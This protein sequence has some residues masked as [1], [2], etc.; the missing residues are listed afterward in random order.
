MRSALFAGSALAM[1]LSPGLASAQDTGAHESVALEEIVVTAQRREENLQKAALP[2][3]AVSQDTLIDAG[4]TS[5]SDLTKVVP[6]LQVKP[7]AGPYPLFYL[8]GVGNFNGNGLS[9]S[10][11]AFNV[12]NVYIGRP[13]SSGGFFYDLERMEVLKG[14]QGTL[15]GRNATGGAI[16]VITKKPELGAFGGYA[17][18]DYGNYDAVNLQGAVNVPLGDEAALRVSG[19]Y[20]KHDGYLSDGSSDEDSLAFRA[21]VRVEPTDALSLRLTGDYYRQDGRGV[22]SSLV[23]AGI[24]AAGAVTPSGLSRATGLGNPAAGAIFS[25]QLVFTGGNFLAPPPNDSFLDNGFWGVSGDIDWKTE[26]GTLTIIPA[27]RKAELHFRNTLPGFLINQRENDEQVSLEARFASREDL[28]LR[29]LVG[30]YYLKEDI[31]VPAVSFNQ[32]FNGSYQSYASDLS[33]I[34]GFGR[35]TWAV[36][37][38]FRLTGGLRYTFEDKKLAGRLYSAAVLCSGTVAPGTTPPTFCFGGPRL[39]NT[40]A[41]PP[42]LVAP[43]GRAIPFQPFGFGSAFPGGPATT[44]VFLAGSQIDI[45]RKASFEKATWRVGAEWDV[46]ARSLLY[47]SFEKGYKSG[48]FF[49]SS[50]NPVYQPEQIDAWTIGSKNRFLDN[51]LQLNLEAF[52]WKYSDQQI[53]HVSRDSAGVV[54]FATENVGKAEMKGFEIESLFKPFAHTELSANVQYLDAV[55]KDFTYTVPNFGA[56]P[57]AQCAAKPQG[58]VYQLDCSGKRPPNAPKWSIGMGV[59]HTIP[60]GDYQITLR[61]RTNWQSKTLASLEFQNVQYQGAYW[62]SDASIGFGDADGRYTVTA[63]VNNIENNRVLGTATPHPLAPLISSSL[64]APRTYGLR[65]AANF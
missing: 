11:V 28:P 32:Q 53:S 65:L 18:G 59:E 54:I 5:P 29:W 43:N 22:G 42:Q 48:G 60:L 10:A 7:A 15:Y 62:R 41:P 33:T 1:F 23:G 26:I 51:R 17:V 35:L 64:S 56:P 58:P 6:S 57:I 25:H 3:S 52:Y 55:Y 12:D 34:A 21:S 2:V 39:P 19:Q 49:F 27:W 31:D 13:S 9:D 14:P 24:D 61:G 40:A 16:N 38:Q 63:F 45:D 20:A 36:T 30:A 46:A 47:A 8:R 44:P 37:D 4:V 50:D